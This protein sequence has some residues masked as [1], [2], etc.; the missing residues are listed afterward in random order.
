MQQEGVLEGQGGKERGNSS[1]MK[2]NNNQNL[3]SHPKKLDNQIGNTLR[4]VTD[5]SKM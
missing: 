1:L 5:Q 3:L 2:T 4:Y